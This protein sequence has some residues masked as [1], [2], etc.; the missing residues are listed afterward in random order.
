LLSLLYASGLR[1][2]SNDSGLAQW[3]SHSYRPSHVHVSW[4]D[5]HCLS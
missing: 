5:F 2:R 3:D 4:H 1:R